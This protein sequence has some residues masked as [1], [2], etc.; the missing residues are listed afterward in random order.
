MIT[1]ITL[2]EFK[3]LASQIFT[4]EAK[5]LKENFLFDGDGSSDVKKAIL[6]GFNFPP[7]FINVVWADS[8]AL[9]DHLNQKFEQ[10]LSKNDS[11]SAFFKFYLELD[12]DNQQ[13]MDEYIKNR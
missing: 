6:F 4:E 11:S 13:M 10:I 3:K 5:T 7:D 2:S 1:K 8:P 12:N 9:A